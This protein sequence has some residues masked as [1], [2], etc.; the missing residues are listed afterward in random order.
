MWIGARGDGWTGGWSLGLIVA[1]LL[2]VLSRYVT[3]H[4][5]ILRSQQAFRVTSQLS[6]LEAVLT[7]AAAGRR[8]VVLRARR[9][10]RRHAGRALGSLA[11]VVAHRGADLGWAWNLAE[12]RRLTVIGGPI[13]LTGTIS[14]LFYSLDKLMILAYLSDRE[15][16]LGCYSLALMVTVA[17]DGARRH[18][19]DRDGP[20]IRREIGQSGCRRE[21]ARLS[22][23]ASELQ[24]VA[25]SL[26]GA[27]AIVVAP[28]VL[29]RMLPDYRTGLAPII[30]L[31]PGAPALAVALPA[32]Q[33]L[34]AVARERRAL[35]AISLAT[36]LACWATT[37]PTGGHG[38]V[39]VAMA[40]SVAYVVYWVLVV[41]ASL[42]RTGP[43]AA[44][45]I[46]RH[47]RPDAWPAA[48]GG[49][50]ARPDTLR[51]RR[52]LVPP[53][54]R[55]R[56]RRNRLEPLR[57]LGLARRRLAAGVERRSRV[58]A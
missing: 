26:P 13:L 14:S 56:R 54:R 34:I 55:R 25:M 7:L 30:W 1:G 44:A 2:A 11:F 20:A 43:R 52:S 57:R 21:A 53:G 32:S 46:P 47:A 39:G 33:Y 12:I 40:T 35:A 50:R 58:E 37:S 24:A 19:L 23:R 49:H 3:Y 9:T 4:V 10:V 28:P 38:L 27:L 31:V 8:D 48:G 51:G 16:Q 15:F 18:V 42:W 41:A 45:A 29:A 6:V 17:V 36:C 5:T 22:A